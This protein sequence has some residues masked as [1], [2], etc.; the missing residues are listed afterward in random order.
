M[1][2]Y[3]AKTISDYIICYYEQ[4]GGVVSNLKL[5]KILYFL[6]AEYIVVKNKKL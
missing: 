5:Q 6:Q 4:N 1:F 3:D 2:M